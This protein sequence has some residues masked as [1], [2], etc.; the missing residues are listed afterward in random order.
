MYQILSDRYFTP[1][2]GNPLRGV[3]QGHASH[4]SKRT[5]TG[6]LPGPSGSDSLLDSGALQDVILGD[7]RQEIG[8]GEA[9]HG[10]GFGNSARIPTSSQSDMRDPDIGR[11]SLGKFSALT[12]FVRLRDAAGEL[13]YWM[14]L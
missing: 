2:Y 9:H 3:K 14:N 5:S 11:D 13:I 7:S 4:E 1:L 6:S 8:T 10:K 12:G